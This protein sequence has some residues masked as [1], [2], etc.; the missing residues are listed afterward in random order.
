MKIKIIKD[1]FNDN[2]WHREGEVHNLDKDTAR[3]YIHKG[4]G[5]EYK[6]EKAR[7]E[8]KEEKAAIETKAEKPKRRTRKP[9]AE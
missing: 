5:I 9:K 6:E 7:K 4:L 3:F 2:Q 8:T 1:V